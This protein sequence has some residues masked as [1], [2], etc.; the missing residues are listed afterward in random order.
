MLLN[1]IIVNRVVYPKRASDKV[2]QVLVVNLVDRI[3][4]IVGVSNR[5]VG[6]ICQYLAVAISMY[7]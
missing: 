1:W 7:Y 6:I 5:P 4:P 3:Y 2:A